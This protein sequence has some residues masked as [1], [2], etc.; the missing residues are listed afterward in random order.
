MLETSKSTLA[1]AAIHLHA[2]PRQ[3]PS[4]LAGC[5]PPVAV[6]TPMNRHLFVSSR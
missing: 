3:C 2:R 1:T 6:G 5:P 4:E